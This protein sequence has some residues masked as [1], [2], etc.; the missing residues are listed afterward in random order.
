M[1]VHISGFCEEE[2]EEEFLHQYRIPRED[3]KAPALINTPVRRAMFYEPE[4][5]VAVVNTCVAQ[6]LMNYGR[7]L[8]ETGTEV[9]GKR[10]KVFEA[11]LMLPVN[12][13]YSRHLAENICIQWQWEGASEKLLER[14]AQVIGSRAVDKAYEKK[15]YLICI[16][17]LIELGNKERAKTVLREYVSRYGKKDIHFSYPAALLSE[18]LGISNDKIHKAAAICKVIIQND[19]LLEK[20]IAGKSI[21]VVGSGPY[22]LGRGKGKEIDSHDVVIRFNDYQTNEYRQDYG[23]RTDIWVRNIDTEGG[24]C[25][26]RLN[27][28]H[29]YDL[30]VL[31]SN[32]WRFFIPEMFLDVF[33][34]YAQKN[35][36]RLCMLK[37]RDKM[38]QEMGSFPTS[39]GQLLFELCQIRNRIQSIDVYGFSYLYPTEGN[40][41]ALKHISDETEKMRYG[42]LHHNL[43]VE[44]EYLRT[45]MGDGTMGNL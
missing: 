38:I 9:Y 22:E 32:I 24:G 35:G 11:A 18:E 25:N 7:F 29:N 19:N 45:L 8:N 20:Y 3:V 34:Q 5:T 43:R 6:V 39:G 15:V 28:V 40:S 4:K 42:N 2:N 37:Y 14:C 41:K 12:Q 27:E 26:P 31:E 21:A 23:I 1:G 17:S 30:V 44:A 16:S 36:K 10:K 13:N 33:Y